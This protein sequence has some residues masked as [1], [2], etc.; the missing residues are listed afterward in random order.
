[1]ITL[2]ATSGAIGHLLLGHVKL[3]KLLALAPRTIA[4]TQ[5]GASIARRAK[6]QML[7]MIL[8]ITLIMITVI[9]LM[10]KVDY[11]PHRRQLPIMARAQ[12]PSPGSQMQRWG[13][14]F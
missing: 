6:F 11:V 2:I 13:I 1:M 14:R 10:N 8:L 7:R 3:V 4:G 12:R 5:I 9:L